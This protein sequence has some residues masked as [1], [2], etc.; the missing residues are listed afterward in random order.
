VVCCV[1][2]WRVAR[3][4]VVHWNVNGGTVQLNLLAKRCT[5]TTNLYGQYGF[6]IMYC[7][8]YFDSGELELVAFIGWIGWYYW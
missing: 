7:L 1:V 4:G 8:D 6:V 5:I 3:R 2:S